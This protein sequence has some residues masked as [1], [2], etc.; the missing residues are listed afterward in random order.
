MSNLL[1]PLRSSLL[2]SDWVDPMSKTIAILCS[3]QGTQYAAMFDLVAQAP[4]ARPILEAAQEVLEEDPQ[5]FVRKADEATLFSNRMGQVLC[6]TQAL[7]AWAIIRPH[8]PCHVVLAGYSVG[9]LAAW[10]CAGLLK[11]VDLLRIAVTRAKVMDEAGGNRGGLEAVIGLNQWQVEALC[12]AHDAHIA[13]INGEDFFIVGGAQAMLKK[14]REEALKNGAIR[15]TLLRVTVPSHTPLMAEASRRF[16]EALAQVH[17]PD[18]IPQGIRLLSGVD[19]DPVLDVFQGSQ[20][21]A[22]QISHTLNWAACLDSCLAANAETFL[23]L[24]PGRAL[25]NMTRK[26][27][28]Q[29]RVRSLDDFR[30]PAGLLAW[31][32]PG[33]H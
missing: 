12:R 21:L 18:R 8:L 32:N 6:C 3:G 5:E 10:G 19:G 26:L 11:P 9:E 29:S 13:I 27:L 1:S 24:G 25:A 22:A 31:L 16:G 23:E 15:A 2:L 17:L 30:A 4:E 28:P 14:I 20:K 33:D 7:A